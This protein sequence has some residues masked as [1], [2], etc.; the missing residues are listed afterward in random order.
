MKFFNSFY[1]ITCQ[2]TGTYRLK[3]KDEEKRRH[4]Y[5]VGLPADCNILLWCQH[6]R[7]NNYLERMGEVLQKREINALR[8]S[9]MDI[10]I[11]KL[12]LGIW[13]IFL[14]GSP[15]YFIQYYLIKIHTTSIFGRRDL[16]HFMVR[17]A[18]LKDWT[19]WL[20]KFLSL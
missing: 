18:F 3:H 4:K 12:L 19:S 16:L 10:I 2:T 9:R 20:Y 14:H 17:I 6:T 5:Q 11:K 7:T 1:W 15:E 8:S 13:N